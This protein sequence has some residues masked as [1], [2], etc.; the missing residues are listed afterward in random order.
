MDPALQGD[1]M[2]YDLSAHL[3]SSGQALMILETLILF[4]FLHPHVAISCLHV[5]ALLTYST[6]PTLPHPADCSTS[7][8]LKLP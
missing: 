6:F 8:K 2:G 7:L 5:F 1:G 3:D 4:A